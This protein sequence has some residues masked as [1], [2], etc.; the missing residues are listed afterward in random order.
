MIRAAM[1]FIGEMFVAD[2]KR[3]RRFSEISNL[4]VAKALFFVNRVNNFPTFFS[5]NVKRKKE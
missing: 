5:E 2:T 3:H 1:I 4:Q